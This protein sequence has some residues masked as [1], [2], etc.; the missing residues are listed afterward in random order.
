VLYYYIGKLLNDKTMEHSW[1]DKVLSQIATDLKEQMPTLRGF[2]ATFM[3][4]SELP[5]EI[6]QVSPIAINYEN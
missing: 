6:Q 2:S 5:A 3:N 1:G 4:S